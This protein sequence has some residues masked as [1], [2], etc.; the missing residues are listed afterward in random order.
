MGGDERRTPLEKKKG[1][2]KANW[3]VQC[4][5]SGANRRRGGPEKA[6]RKSSTLDNLDGAT[7]LKKA[8]VSGGWGL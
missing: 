1:G 8:M 7:R 6:N 4:D 5:Q 2:K 3:R